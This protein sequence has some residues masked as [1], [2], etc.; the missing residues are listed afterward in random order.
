MLLDF[1]D[2]HSPYKAQVLGDYDGSELHSGQ[3]AGL[4]KS[5]VTTSEVVQGIVNEI[6]PKVEELHLKSS[7]FS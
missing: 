4:I 1:I 2:E 6:S 3:V 5:V 7:I